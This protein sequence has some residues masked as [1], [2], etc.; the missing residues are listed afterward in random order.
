MRHG[1]SLVELS[2]VLV[3]LGLLTGGI[4]A[5]QSLI[6]AAELRSV[7][8]DFERYQTAHLAFR[9]RYLGLAGDITNATSFWGQAASSA[10]CGATIGTGTQTCNGNG[11][12]QIAAV[13]AANSH[14]AYRAWQQLANAGLIEGSFSG[15]RNASPFNI[16]GTNIPASRI[17]S[18]GFALY[19]GGKVTNANW[20]AGEYQHHLSFGPVGTQYHMDKGLYGEEVWSIDTKLDDGMPGTGIIVTFNSNTEPE[21]VS[22]TTPSSATY[23]LSD[24]SGL[25]AAL[26]R[27]MF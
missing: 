27:N 3:I 15:V 1:F 5:G 6:R 21:C 12:G 11:D 13:P 24:R 18:M 14:E 25:C 26:R 17:S 23:I 8:K 16:I 4:L 10:T 19:Y 22:S 7:T 2:I 9:D 20:F